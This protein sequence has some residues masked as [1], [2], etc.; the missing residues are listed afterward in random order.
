MPKIRQVC[1]RSLLCNL[2]TTSVLINQI[3]QTIYY[4]CEKHKQKNFQ[5][6]LNVYTMLYLSYLSPKKL[7]IAHTRNVNVS[8]LDSLGS[9]SWRLN[10]CWGG[11]KNCYPCCKSYLDIIKNRFVRQSVRGS[12]IVRRAFP[13]LQLKYVFLVVGAK[14]MLKHVKHTRFRGILCI[15]NVCLRVTQKA[16][17]SFWSH[18]AFC[19]LTFR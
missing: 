7:N 6:Q 5:C 8:R 9:G 15:G 3:W 16:N 10:V 1:A 18:F 19:Y 2:A 11:N 4:L 14:Y 17:W 12:L 13:R